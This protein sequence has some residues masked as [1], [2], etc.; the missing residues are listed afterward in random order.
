M[1]AVEPT[2][3]SAA[4]SAPLFPPPASR[5][6]GSNFTGPN[7]PGTSPGRL[8][9]RG[10]WAH[11][12]NL[13][14]GHRP[15]APGKKA[16][17]SGSSAPLRR[18][19]GVTRTGREARDPDWSRAEDGRLVLPAIADTGQKHVVPWA[20]QP[21]PSSAS[22]ASRSRTSSSTAA[23]HA[24]GATRRSRC[25]PRARRRP[26]SR[27]EYRPETCSDRARGA[28]AYEARFGRER[29]GG[30][31]ALTVALAAGRGRE[32][33]SGDRREGSEGGQA[34]GRRKTRSR[35][36]SGAV[37]LLMEVRAEYLASVANAPA[38]GNSSTTGRCSQRGRARGS[39]EGDD[40][41]RRAR[42]AARSSSLLG[43]DRATDEVDADDA[44]RLTSSR[45]S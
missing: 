39:R 8:P 42:S 21:D 40:A 45:T 31:F 43:A 44:R 25:S 13:P 15:C 5:W 14:P 36:R 27:P 35:D 20:A 11:A 28:Q 24:S 26:R 34:D 18:A 17:T 32:S 1:N 19:A 7:K 16:S 9:G 22:C 33:P 41:Q 3:R 6:R 23:S 12:W 37:A 4:A 2:R 30:W 29:G 10:V 38:T